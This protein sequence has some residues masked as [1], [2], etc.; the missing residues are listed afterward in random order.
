MR[1]GSKAADTDDIIDKKFGRL[2]V[3]RE[4]F[5]RTYTGKRTT[6]VRFYE[7]RCSCGK[8]V[9]VRRTNLI[10]CGTESCGCKRR[11]QMSLYPIGRKSAGVGYLNYMFRYYRRNA[12][13]NSIRF[14]LTLEEFKSCVSKNCRYCGAHPVQGENQ[15]TSRL[16]R[17]FNGTVPRNGVDRLIPEL[18]Y[19]SENVVPCCRTCNIAKHTM[20]EQEFYAWIHRV[21]SHITRQVTN[22]AEA[23]SR[24]D[25][26]PL[27]ST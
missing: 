26:V 13:R 8:V 20:T 15:K 23:P 6:S 12:A 16:D 25:E 18:G 22:Q 27:G 4:A 1:L 21:H 2:T 10:C 7:C 19:V 14:S 17:T 9:N 11:E 3:I 24:M 5:T